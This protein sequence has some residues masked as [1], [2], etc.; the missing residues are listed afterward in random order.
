MLGYRPARAD[1]PL[2]A[3]CPTP[4]AMTTPSPIS[5]DR[6]DANASIDETTMLF[7]DIEGS[8]RLLADLGEVVYAEVL[9][10]HH[11]L[12]RTA[13][14][15]HGGEEVGT[16]GDSFFVIFGRPS[17]AILAAVDAQ[18]ALVGASWPA[19]IRVRVRMGLHTGPI[20]RAGGNLVGMAI[21]TAARIKSAA[22]GGQIV[23]SAATARDAELDDDVTL[24][25][26]G[27][28]SFARHQRAGR[29]LRGRSS[30]PVERL[31]VTR[32]RAIGFRRGTE[33]LG[34]TCGTGSRT[35]GDRAAARGASRRD[36]HGTA[37]W[38]QDPSRLGDRRRKERRGLRR[39]GVAR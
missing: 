7:T 32:I 28:A 19:G 2:G 23:V 15:D 1:P 20:A 26:L 6:H 10:T 36:D 4:S 25:Q 24:D 9:A 11:R 16:E 14:L 39:P 3:I 37:G 18:R 34:R 5:S 13:M 35:G 33:A 22:H 27:I 31:S 38:R 12:I 21:H 17:D 29:A 30:R 8:T